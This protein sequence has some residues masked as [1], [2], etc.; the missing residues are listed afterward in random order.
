MLSDTNVTT[1]TGAHVAF[2]MPFDHVIQVAAMTTRLT[3]GVESL[4]CAMTIGG[5]INTF[6][7]S[8]AY[9]YV[10]SLEGL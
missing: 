3:A 1:P 9:T 5:N 2:P 10:Q 4:Y 8:I 6:D 7:N